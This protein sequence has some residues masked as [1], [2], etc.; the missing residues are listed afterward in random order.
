M[1][2]W[3]WGAPHPHP[4]GCHVLIQYCHAPLMLHFSYS[5][6]ASSFQDIAQRCLCCLFLLQVK[7]RTSTVPFAAILDGRQKLPKDY[8][9][10]FA[11]WPYVAVTCFTLG[12]YLCHP[13]MQQ[14]SYS[15]H[16]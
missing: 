3:H 4:P 12:A 9:K 8:W 7:E 5:C 2:P 6:K 14:A 10:E 15:L 11:R 1:L 13:L 16:W